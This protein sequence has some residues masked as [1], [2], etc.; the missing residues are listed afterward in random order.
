M[1]LAHLNLLVCPDCHRDLCCTQ[2]AQG[3]GQILIDGTLACSGC[4]REF[5]VVGGVPRF[6]PRENY[7]SGFGL[8]WTR[9]AR[10]QY[11]SYC[12]LPLSQQRFFGQ[13]QWPPDLRGE[14][15]LEVGSGSGRFTEQAANTGATVVS[16]DYSYA[17]DANHASN[18]GRANVL[19][20]QADVFAMPFRAASFDKV[21]CFGML[22]H[23]PNPAKA[24]ATLPRVLR[25]G[26]SLCAD[27]YKATLFRAFLHTK[28]YVRPFT[29]RMNPDRLYSAVCAWVNFMWPIASV[30]RRLPKGYA[31]NWRFM[32][33]DYSFLGL[34]GQLLKE[35]SY[36]DTFDMLAPRYDRPARIRTVR[37]WARDANLEAVAAEYTP[38]G[39]VLRATVPAAQGAGYAAAAAH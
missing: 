19:I 14:T 34:K 8:E 1:N 6:V 13:T 33:A 32:V 9:H 5:P 27:I 11:D 31:I 25:A 10:T 7:A 3:T 23:T 17:V 18:G 24:F 30:I 15:I 20:V 22:Q 26:G 21:F 38:H 4:A 29:R 37:R 12:G 2:S 36:L 35:W 28:Y 16:L 39:I